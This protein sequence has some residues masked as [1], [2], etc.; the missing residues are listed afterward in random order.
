LNF[1]NQTKGPLRYDYDE[2]YITNPSHLSDK[3]VWVPCMPLQF[4]AKISENI[5]FRQVSCGAYHTIAVS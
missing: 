4:L 3:K 2:S 1:Q 5:K